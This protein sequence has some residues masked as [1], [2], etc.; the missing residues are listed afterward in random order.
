VLGLENN[1]FWIPVKEGALTAADE[2]A[3][4]NTTVEWIVPGE[5]HLADDFAGSI[6]ALVAQGYDAIATIAGDYGVVPFIDAAAAAGIPIATFNSETTTPNAR[7]FFV[8]P[9]LYQQGKSA[10]QTMAETIGSSGKVGII[11]GF[12]AVEAYELRR[13][14][15]VDYLAENHPNIVIVGEVENQGKGDV[16]FTQ[17]Q[18]FMTA[19][20]DLA[21]IYITGDGPFGV[22]AAVEDA[23]M[24][25][26]VAV[27]SFDFIDETMEYV[28]SGVINATIGQGPFAQGHDP[29]V[30]LFNY[31]VGD[32]VP[33]CGR[34]ITE[35][36]VVTAENVDQYWI[37]P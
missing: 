33:E 20:P 31:L 11:T 35:A 21:G 10:A 18:D 32:I 23:G 7:L 37:A 29:A 19:N 13:Q 28:Q 8:G 14:G 4:Y 9:D 12:F 30:R 2:L 17:A 22:A 25:G 36:A 3:S 15:F 27:V 26:E 1:P 24:A 34:M 5:T 6:E 16:A